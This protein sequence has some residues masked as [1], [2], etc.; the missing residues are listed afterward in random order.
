M[1]LCDI[2]PVNVHERRFLKANPP[3]PKATKMDPEPQSEPVEPKVKKRSK[4]SS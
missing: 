4:K 3:K 2:H 1:Q